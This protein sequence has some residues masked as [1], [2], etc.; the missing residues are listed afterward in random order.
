MCSEFNMQKIVAVSMETKKRGGLYNFFYDFSKH[1]E[2]SLQHYV[3][4]FVSDLRQVGGF[5]L[6]FRFPIKV[7]ATI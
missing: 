6:V 7:T 2:T 5:P 3:I 1:D 4:K